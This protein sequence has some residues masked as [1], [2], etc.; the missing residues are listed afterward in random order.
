MLTRTLAEHVLRR[1]LGGASV[2]GGSLGNTRVAVSGDTSVV[3][4]LGQ[5]AAALRRL[6]EL[7]VTPPV[8]AWGQC[9]PSGDSPQGS[10][11]PSDRSRL[12]PQPARERAGATHVGREWLAEVAARP[13]ATYEFDAGTAIGTARRERDGKFRRRPTRG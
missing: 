3:L 1:D 7:G 10:T 13:A 11:A 8:L 4:K 6:A 12:H 2:N 9:P 5:P